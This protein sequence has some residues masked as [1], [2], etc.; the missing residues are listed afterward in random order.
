M[1]FR[2]QDLTSAMEN[3][4]ANIRDL[5]KAEKFTKEKTLGG[6]KY[7]GDELENEIK[8]LKTTICSDHKVSAWP[9]SATLFWLS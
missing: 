1:S 8:L 9:V 5:L 6:W 7:F 3:V 2:Q 4:I